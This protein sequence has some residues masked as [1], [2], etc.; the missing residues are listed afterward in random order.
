MFEVGGYHPRQDEENS[1]FV[2]FDDSGVARKRLSSIVAAGT[3]RGGKGCCCLQR[4]GP[5]AT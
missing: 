5:L 1:Y 2:D 4:D 3:F